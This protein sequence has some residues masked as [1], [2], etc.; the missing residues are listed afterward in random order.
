[1]SPDCF[2][3]SDRPQVSV[4]TLGGL[5]RH[6]AETE[7][8]WV[9]F[10]VD[11]PAALGG[12]ERDEIDWSPEGGLEVDPE[13]AAGWEARFRLQPGETLPGVLGRYERVARRTDKLV[14]TL[15]DLDVAHALPPAPWFEKGARWSARRT[16]LHVI[17]E[18]AQHAGHADIIHESLDGQKSMG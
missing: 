9:N 5:I 12:G 14:A 13:V 4:L 2:I 1:V 10:I 8:Q 11:G 6:V 15:P 3:Y 16:L 7:E 17:A 18:T